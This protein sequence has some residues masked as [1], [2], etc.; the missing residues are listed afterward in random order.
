MAAGATCPASGA[1]EAAVGRLAGLRSGRRGRL[2]FNSAEISGSE[3]AVVATSER[4]APAAG[5]TSR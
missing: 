5:G 2:A 1:R 4:R 3:L